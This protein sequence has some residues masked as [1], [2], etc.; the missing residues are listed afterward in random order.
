MILYGTACII[1]LIDAK[2]FRVFY[3]KVFELNFYTSSISHILDVCLVYYPSH[4]P[5]F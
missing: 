1:I 2:V 4:H 5:V 3:L